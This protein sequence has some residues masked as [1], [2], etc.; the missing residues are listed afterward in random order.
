[1]HNLLHEA[2]EIVHVGP[3]AY[4]GQWPME[5]TIGNLG[6][7]MKQ[8]SNP[9]ANLSQR[10]VRRAQVNALKSLIPDIEPD[11]ELPRGSEDL[12]HGYILLRA[13]DEYPQV[14]HGA[15]G[16]VIRQ[17]LEEMNDEK[18]PDIFQPK[19]RRWARLRL[20][21][22]QIARSAWKEK[23]KALDK[24]RM[25][26]NVRFTDLDGEESYAEVQFFFQA[27]S[28]DGETFSLALIHP[29]S[30]PD[31][32][33]LE[34]SSKT[35]WVCDGLDEDTPM[36]VIEVDSIS[37]VVGM[38]LFDEGRVFVVHKMGLESPDIRRIPFPSYD[39]LEDPF[40]VP[41]NLE[42]YDGFARRRR[43]SF[44][45][46]SDERPLST[47]TQPNLWDPAVAEA[48][49]E[50]LMTNRNLQYIKVYDA[51]RNLHGR[52]Q[53]AQ[54]A[55]GELQNSASAAYSA[56]V[57]AVSDRLS[58]PPCTHPAST[59]SSTALVPSST[60]TDH[61]RILVQSDYPKIN[62]WTESDYR[63]E[64]KRRQNEKG[65]ATM[66]DAK[67][68]R[69][70]KRLAEDDENVMFWF[71]EDENGDSIP[72]KRAKAARNQARKIWRYLD[73]LGRLPECW[74]DADALVSSYYTGEMRR[75]F[76]ELQLCECDY[77][78]HRIATL[79]F[80][81]FIK[82]CNVKIKEEIKEDSDVTD[83]AAA[84]VVAGEKR[85]AS[86]A[87]DDEP[88]PKRT[89][90]SGRKPSSKSK[91]K[92]KTTKTS[93]K[94]S[95][96]A[97]AALSAAPEPVSAAPVSPPPA[98]AP[99][100][101]E[102]APPLPPAA[103]SQPAQPSQPAL[104]SHPTPPSHPVQPIIVST[105]PATT[106]VSVAPAGTLSMGNDANL[107][108]AINDTDTAGPPTATGPIPVTPQVTALAAG[109][110][111]VENPLAFL[112]DP[113]GPT[114]RADF[115]AGTS[116]GPVKKKPGARSNKTDQHSGDSTKPLILHKS[117]AK[118]ARGLCLQDYIH[119][120]RS[121]AKPVFDTYFG[122]LPPADLKMWEER[123]A[124]A[125][126]AEKNSAAQ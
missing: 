91:P 39:D 117:N 12:G 14:I 81:N 2:P 79:I 60:S 87:P 84:A 80:P 78:A 115:V 112:G 28:A 96:P 55:Y 73:N 18:Y 49:H 52:F 16:E 71:I 113:K 34:V 15:Q 13:K 23:Q 72:G 33:L 27:D 21:N 101:T 9:Y 99:A 43:D 25:A 6:E 94:S 70:S 74:N 108:P 24:V 67:G 103:P 47:R 51:H 56:L 59:E 17:Y 65:K 119:A 26:R 68:Q 102:P 85:A 42:D 40:R 50:S 64:E 57:A 7:E 58:A 20:P 1:M 8:H 95:L 86:E 36:E 30:A 111:T 83:T 45:A 38:V 5:R 77:K 104:P 88:A 100:T 46:P 75:F 41:S 44:A 22:G 126:Q 125:K 10:G 61:L 32:D 105:P 114:T 90:A 4:H 62:Y 37:S 122:S 98:P 92:L 29:Y 118:T 110:S 89:A 107:A 123:S 35:L 97:P 120:H 76:P 93:A 116:A 63:K 69:G 3:G 31:P 53:A 54:Q 106:L 66:S 19:L 124:T 48:T 82:R 121:V 11:D 109:K